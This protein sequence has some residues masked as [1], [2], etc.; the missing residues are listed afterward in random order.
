MIVAPASVSHK[1]CV[2]VFCSVSRPDKVIFPP[3]NWT[4]HQSL[5]EEQDI[6][7]ELQQVYEVQYAGISYHY[8]SPISVGDV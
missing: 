4:V 3:P 2:C 1:L 6:G 8:L 7:P 5:S